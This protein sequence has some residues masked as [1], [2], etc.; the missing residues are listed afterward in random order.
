M[1]FSK[2]LLG[3]IF[4]GGLSGAIALPAKANVIQYF[5]DN[6]YK[7]PAELSIVP[8]AQVTAGMT[9]VNPV[10]EFNGVSSGGSGKASTNENDLLPYF[11]AAFRLSP[12]WVVG[13]NVSRLFYGD[14]A[15]PNDSILRF[16]S[17]QTKVST[18][19]IGPQV[20]YQ[21]T[22]KL[23]IGA[24]Y[25]F[26]D[27][28]KTELNFVEP[29]FG[30]AS[31]ESSGWY[32][33]WNAGLFYTLTPQDYISLAYFSTLS[34]TTQTGRSSVGNLVN[35]QY[36]LRGAYTPATTVLDYIHIF[37]REW[38]TMVKVSYSQW[39][40][41]QNLVLYNVVNYGIFTMPLHYRNT[42]AAQLGARYAFNPDWAV[43]GGVGFDQGASNNFTRSINFPNDNI[44]AA[45]VGLEHQFYKTFTANLMYTY[46][47]V[48]TQVNHPLGISQS[49]GNINVHANVLDL[50]L[51]YKV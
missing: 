30:N 23:A 12:Q 50:S 44:Y 32:H 34:A 16:D 42:Y 3:Y 9:G 43:L 18:I 15:Y 19:D 37:N 49:L 5:F 4:F 31:N 10:M 41:I 35:S 24:G 22:K 46:A 11:Y 27:F 38:S 40:S 29:G 51:T 6:N 28:Y 39:S 47:F 13:L 14:Q 17:T 45:T 2:K 36:A 21:V 7:N 48:R 33:G 1:R 25:N 20:S 26:D 8:R